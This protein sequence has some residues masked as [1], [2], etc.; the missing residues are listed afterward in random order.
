MTVSKRGRRI[1]EKKVREWKEGRRE[2]R[3]VAKKDERKDGTK[4]EI[5]KTLKGRDN[6]LRREE[7]GQS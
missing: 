6:R 2:R 5:R 3:K 1:D 7:N 4:E